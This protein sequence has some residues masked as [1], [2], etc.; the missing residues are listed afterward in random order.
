MLRRRPL[1]GA[2]A[3]ATVAAAA[4]A[5]PVR[6]SS[7]QLW[8]TVSF[9]GTAAVPLRPF[10][11]SAIALRVP[12]AST[13]ATRPTGGANTGA[14]DYGMHYQTALR[15]SR[16][17]LSPHAAVPQGSRNSIAGPFRTL[18]SAGGTPY[19][20]DMD[21]REDQRGPY[22][23]TIDEVLLH[24]H[25]HGRGDAAGA[26]GT[27]ADLVRLLVDPDVKVGGGAVEAVSL[28]D[29]VAMTPKR[30]L[31]AVGGDAECL[32]VL[33]SS[34]RY[35]SEKDAREL[36]LLGVATVGQW[37]EQPDRVQLSA[38]SRGVLETAYSRLARHQN[39]SQSEEVVA[40]LTRAIQRAVADELMAPKRLPNGAS[41]AVPSAAPF[42][43]DLKASAVTET[44]TA[45][46]DAAAS[47]HAQPLA[48][49]A[50]TVTATERDDDS[51]GPAGAAS[52]SGNSAPSENADEI[53]PARRRGPRQRSV[54]SGTAPKTPVVEKDEVAEGEELADIPD[55][56]AEEVL[57]EALEGDEVVDDE[58]MAE[59]MN[60]AE[61]IL[62]RDAAPAQSGAEA[63]PTKRAGAASPSPQQ[64][65]ATAVAP[66]GRYGSKRVPEVATMVPRQQQQQQHQLPPRHEIEEEADEELVE[67]VEEEV[68]EAEEEEP[69]ATAQPSSP[70]PSA[71]AAAPPPPSP[72][73]AA[74]RVTAA[75]RRERLARLAELMLKQFN[76]A[77]GYLHPTSKD[78]RDAQ[79]QRGDILVLDEDTAQVDPLAMFSAYHAATVTDADP[80]G[81]RA[82]KTIWTSYNKHQMALEEA[83]DGAAIE[84]YK[85]ESVNA[86]LYGSVL[87][88]ALA[89]E[90][91]VVVL[92]GTS[93][94]PYGFPLVSSDTR[95][96]TVFAAT[97][98]SSS[99]I[100]SVTDMTSAKV[101]AAIQAYKVFFTSKDKRHSPFRP[102]I[103]QSAGC[104]V[105]CLS[106]TTLHLYYTSTKDRILEEEVRLPF[107]E[108]MLGVLHLLRHKVL[109][110]VNVVHYHLIATKMVDPSESTDFMLRSA[111]TIDLTN[112]FSKEEAVRL[113]AL[114]TPL[115][116]AD[117][118]DEFRCIDDL[119]MDIEET[120]GAS[121]VH[122]LLH[123]REDLEA[124]LTATLAQ[125]LPEDGDGDG[126]AGASETAENV[127]MEEDE[128][129]EEEE[130]VEAALPPPPSRK[131]K[132]AAAAPV[133]PP[134]PTRSGRRRALQE[135]DEEETASGKSK[136]AAEAAPARASRGK[137]RQLPGAPMPNAAATQAARDGEEQEGARLGEAAY[138]QWQQQQR[139]TGKTG[140]A[141]AAVPKPAAMMQH[142]GG[143]GGPSVEEEDLKEELEEVE[144]LEEEEEFPPARASA[145]T[146]V[147]PASAAP[148]AGTRTRGAGPASAVPLPSRAQRS[149]RAVAAAAP[150]NGEEYEDDSV[151]EVEVEEEIEVTAAPTIPRALPGRRAV[152]VAAAPTRPSPSPPPPAP[153]SRRATQKMDDDEALQVRVRRGARRS[154]A[155]ARAS[156]PAAYEGLEEATAAAMESAPEVGVADTDE[157]QWFKKRPKRR[158]FE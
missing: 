147:S 105:V 126:A 92:E 52:P 109:P 83:T 130:D 32:E 37:R 8:M 76:T 30:K 145:R 125:L 88:R 124:T 35:Q 86:L 96:F 151:E 57:E 41:T 39:Q 95:P 24:S 98:A 154:T 25:D 119:V 40:W 46:A 5:T 6:G 91:Q 28:R 34:E 54:A 21:A 131:A 68:E 29:F 128:V 141:A 113:R 18:A 148:M 64:P 140:A 36:R 79:E 85:R 49:R 60:E 55:E 137:H 87:M 133:P 17:L 9:G 56:D 20:N 71:A 122:S 59:L 102:A 108:V 118:M 19:Y 77:D 84:F 67:E 103:D 157:D 33:L 134:S 129:V 13:R 27:V 73:T 158:Y 153:A 15:A 112:P 107:A 16:V 116:M 2:A 80:I 81:V 132:G 65:P 7:G 110:R 143:D 74:G 62:G 47:R 152:P 104:S 139:G 97:G 115:G 44:G 12:L 10:G 146:P 58:E 14:S 50:A 93:M 156:P 4:T 106:G 155:R 72:A 66:G 75:E 114:A 100:A 78:E 45:P 123:N 69:V 38:Y 135:E 1:Q 101:L 120:S 90:E 11:D 127:E 138:S 48:Q 111:A 117:E 51:E 89:R 22:E 70:A 149:S 3:A 53:A 150:A 136:E 23:V 121:V 94:P 142:S 43:V 63:T 26:V 99:T 61:V 82:L 144:E 42:L 31:K